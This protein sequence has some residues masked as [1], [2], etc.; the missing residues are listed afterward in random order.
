M[1]DEQRKSRAV[2]SLSALGNRRLR[3]QNA[4]LSLE[5]MQKGPTYVEEQAD[6]KRAF[7]DAAGESDE[8]EEGDGIGGGL[9]VRSRGGPKRDEEEEPAE[10][11]VKDMLGAVFGEKEAEMDDGDRFL[12]NFILNKVSSPPPDPPPSLPPS[13]PD[14]E[15]SEGSL[16]HP[17]LPLP[18]PIPS[19]DGSCLW[20]LD[21]LHRAGLRR[22]MTTRDKGTLKW[23]R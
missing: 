12:K 9:K 2:A 16:L 4:L 23:R 8:D 13:H 6:L 5:R 22:G 1:Q 15:A 7:L 19:T 21:R 18:L 14:K 10:A 20:R 17:P 11:K 3:S